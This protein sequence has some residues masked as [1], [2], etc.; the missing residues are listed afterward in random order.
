MIPP[1]KNYFV[2][3]DCIN[4]RKSFNGLTGIIRSGLQRDPAGVMYLSLSA[5]PGKAPSYYS[6]SIAAF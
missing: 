6:G 2:Y 3:T 1:A 4:G 5:S